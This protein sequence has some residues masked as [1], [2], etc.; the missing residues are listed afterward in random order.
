MLPITRCNLFYVGGVGHFCH[1]FRSFQD[2]FLLQKDF[3]FESTWL[4]FEFAKVTKSVQILRFAED[5][6]QILSI[7]WP[8][9]NSSH[10]IR[11]FSDV[12]TFTYF[13]TLLWHNYFDLALM[14]WKFK[15]LGAPIE[16]DSHFYISKIC[17]F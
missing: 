10:V 14:F 16:R 5:T 13:V 6:F 3:Y 1:S 12:T 4:E 17:Q 11:R 9:F 2:K 7:F 15:I 8:N